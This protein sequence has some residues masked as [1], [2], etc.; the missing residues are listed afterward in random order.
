MKGYPMK[1]IYLLIALCLLSAN[2]NAM[3]PYY[4]TGPDAQPDLTPYNSDF[5]NSYSLTLNTIQTITWPAGAN[6]ET[7]TC[8]SAYFESLNSAMIVPVATVTNGT[9][10]ALNAGQRKRGLTESV[11]YIISATT[12]VCTITF[13]GGQ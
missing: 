9:A 2:A 5:I 8:P 1:K 3:L 7:T 11:F 13:W 10:G 4:M 12:Q 6:Y